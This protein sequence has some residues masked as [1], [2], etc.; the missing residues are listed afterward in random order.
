MVSLTPVTVP[1]RQ[2][3]WE[4]AWE[5]QRAFASRADF[6][7][8]VGHARC[9][10]Y[11]RFRQPFLTCPRYAHTAAASG[12]HYSTRGRTL[13][14]YSARTRRGPELQ[15]RFVRACALH[16]GEPSRAAAESRGLLGLVDCLGTLGS[17]WGAWPGLSGAEHGSNKVFCVC[18][19]YG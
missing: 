14:L 17:V 9:P 8:F 13:S 12:Q 10:D 3:C 6:G 4:P 19:A 2:A 1:S 16:R 15:T 7:R 5:L 11:N 18:S